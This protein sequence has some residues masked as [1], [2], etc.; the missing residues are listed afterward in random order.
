MQRVSRRSVA[1]LSSALVAVG[2]LGVIRPAA[3]DPAPARARAAAP[4]PGDGTLGLV[5]GLE[6]GV[7]ASAP[8]NR[9]VDRTDVQV[10]E[11]EVLTGL[12][13]LAVRV[14]AE[15]GAEAL[16][17]LRDDPGVAYVEVD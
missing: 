16:A 12:D 10:V 11:R 14:P 5:V 1:V 2:V 15:D 13:A 9:L 6:S 8:V 4:R 7:G 17:A 3:A